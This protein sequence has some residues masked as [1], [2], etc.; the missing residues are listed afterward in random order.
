MCPI[1]RLGRGVKR[2]TKRLHLW[3][4]FD[5]FAMEC[6]DFCLVLRGI[7]WE[8]WNVWDEPGRK[9]PLEAYKVTCASWVKRWHMVT[10]PIIVRDCDEIVEDSE[11]KD[12]IESPVMAWFCCV[13][14]GKSVPIQKCQFSAGRQ[15]RH[16]HLKLYAH[17]IGV[18]LCWRGVW[19]PQK[20]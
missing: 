12:E 16:Y 9:I 2:I 4:S 5:N 10:E 19:Q 6:G 7:R 18:T 8:I 11:V 3:G 1:W 14:N 15:T 17:I 20:Q 13:G